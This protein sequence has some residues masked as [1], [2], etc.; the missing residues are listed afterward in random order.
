M[1][2]VVLLVLLIALIFLVPLWTVTALTAALTAATVVATFAF[3]TL[4]TLLATTGLV[5][6]AVT[7]TITVVVASSLL[8][9]LPAIGTA[10][11][12]LAAIIPCYAGFAAILAALVAT[13]FAHGARGLFL[14]FVG[15]GAFTPEEAGDF[16]AE[17]PEQAF[18]LIVRS[19]GRCLC[20]GRRRRGGADG[21]H[22]GLFA[23]RLLRSGGLKHFFFALAVFL[24]HL[25]TGDMLGAG[26]VITHADDLEMRRFHMRRRYD[27]KTDFLARFNVSKLL[28]LLVEQE[29]G[30]G[31]RN[32]GPH[33]ARL[34]FGRLFVNQAHD[35]QGEGFNPAD[36]AL[37]LTARADFAAGFTQ[38]RPQALSGHLQQAKAGDLADL[39]P[40]TVDFQRFAHLLLDFALVFGRRH[41][42]E[43]D[44]N[45]AA[46]VAQP[47]LAC[48]LFRGFQV[49]L[50]RGFL[51]VMA[52]GG[53]RGV[54]VDG[55]QRLGRVDNDGT[56]RR[57]LHFTLECSLNLTFDL[58]AAEQRN[59]ILVQLDLVLER[60]HDRAHK[61]QDVF[62]HGGGIDQ[63]FADV[64]AQVVAY[65]TNDDVAFLMDQERRLALAGGLG[66]GFP[67][68]HQIVEVPL[69]LFRGTADAGGAHDNAHGFWHLNVVHGLFQLG[70]LIAFNAAGNTAG[71]GVVGHQD[72]V[73]ACERNECGQSSA[74]VAALF[75]VHLNNDFLAFRDHV[76]DVDLAFDLSRG[77][78]EVL[79]GDFLQGQ[80]AMPVCAEIHK[81]GFEAGLYSGNATLVDVGFFLLTGAGFDI[82]IKQTLAVNEGD[83]QLF[84]MSCIN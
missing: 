10:A 33:F 54:D 63:Y 73:A 60:W 75:L 84:R 21:L 82:K 6:T 34:L 30:N 59:F 36:G 24:G 38:R 3:S 41:V 71:T 1:L 48:D 14:L 9:G 29:G 13:V 18:F 22:C 25:I 72:Q 74:F 7:V 45:Q 51:D 67:E 81:G 42:D 47:Q 64:L 44:H 17:F 57:Q 52:L 76:L 68:L 55:H 50:Q 65:R 61:V 12:A 2:A 80:K 56:A 32:D 83:A 53:A 58:V 35:A 31:D 39:N 27:N 15:R 77:F 37:P 16:T 4:T 43:I 62:V 46:H 40:C 19:S 79:L 26:L 78:L 5:V 20:R 28:A 23:S 70:T 66:D 49:G 69:E 11:V 8:T